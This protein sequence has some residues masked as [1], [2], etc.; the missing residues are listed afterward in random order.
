MLKEKI[1][2]KL[3]SKQIKDFIIY[4][5][6]QAIN[7]ISPLLVIP[8]IVFICG[9]EGLGKAGVGFSFALIA[10][11]L[12]DY[13]SYI[14]GTKD[15]SINH[16]DNAILEDKFTTIYLSK[17]I[18][19][20]AVLLIS[21]LI[22]VS[23][24][25]FQ[26]DKLQLILSL[27][28]VVGQFI[29]PTWFFQGIQNFK[30]ISIINILSKVIYV[31]LIFLLIQKREDYIYI[32]L[33]LGIGSIIASSL[34]FLLIYTQFSFSLKKASIAKAIDLIKSEFSLTI[35]QLFFSFYQYAPIM[36]ISY[37]CGNF[38]AGQYRIIDQVIM[39]FRTYFQMFFNFIYA[40]ICL[41]IY[42]D[43]KS[44][45]TNWKLKNGLNYTMVL[46]LLLIFYFNSEIILLFF[47]VNVRNLDNLNAYFKLGLLIP[48]FMGIS[49]ALKQLMFS[50]NKNKEYIRIT[51]F[52]TTTSLLLMSF[53]LQRIGLNG[54]FI[55]IILAE[56]LFII[57]YFY[58]LYL[59]KQTKS[60]N[61]DRN[62]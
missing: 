30:W 22:I 61:E 29:N 43:V 1:V 34:G 3:K 57:L 46:V 53:L 14:N 6:G 11:V 41:Q 28:I 52:T 24:P 47:K 15:I 38:I 10:I 20:I 45:I 21:I 26:K 50:F 62:H 25:F 39:I 4:G 16:N 60:I 48:F 33:F 19:L 59:K 13:G 58:T 32:N 56:I 8:Y 35:S 27:S 5:F 44:G 54:A 42:K 37:F 51:F 2:T 55:S 23:I 31:V 17:L 40:D 18:L 7:L 9:E 12:V 36:L 49:I